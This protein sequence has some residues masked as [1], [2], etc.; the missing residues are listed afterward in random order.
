VAC[1]TPA[2]WAI[3]NEVFLPEPMPDYPFLPYMK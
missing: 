2:L 1:D 3:S